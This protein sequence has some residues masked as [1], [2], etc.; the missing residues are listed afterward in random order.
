[1]AQACTQDR[2]TFEAGASALIEE[3]EM[4]HDQLDDGDEVYWYIIEHQVDDETL[5]L[6]CVAARTDDEAVE[7]AKAD[8]IDNIVNMMQVP[9]PDITLEELN[10]LVLGVLAS[11]GHDPAEVENFRRLA[12]LVD[13]V[14]H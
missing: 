7:V 11:E 3:M 14:A 5:L 12:E 1:M 6:S 8:G 4:D 10:E 13:D 9:D 2:A